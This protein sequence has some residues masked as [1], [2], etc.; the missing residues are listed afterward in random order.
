MSDTGR[1]GLGQ[2]QE[3]AFEDARS[4]ASGTEIIRVGR[5]QEEQ[6]IPYAAEKQAIGN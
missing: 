5:V 6:K 1:I 2:I 4:E 3:Q